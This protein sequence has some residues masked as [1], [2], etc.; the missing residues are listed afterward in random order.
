MEIQVADEIF[1]G[2]FEKYFDIVTPV[3]AITRDSS[4]MPVLNSSCFHLKSKN[5]DFKGT[6][7]SN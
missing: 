2:E 6:V 4:V 3:Q 5:L 7:F 1:L